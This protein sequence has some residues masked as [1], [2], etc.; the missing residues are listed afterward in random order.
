MYG[1]QE[2]EFFVSAIVWVPYT[3]L[4]FYLFS[5]HY[6][7]SRNLQ[8]NILLLLAS[9]SVFRCAWFFIDDKVWWITSEIVNRIAL[10]LQFSGLS[11]LMLMWTRA[12]AISKMTDIAFQESGGTETNSMENG[13]DAVLVDRLKLRLQR[14]Q[15]ATQAV[16]NKLTSMNSFQHYIIITVLVNVV[17]WGFVLG[18][19]AEQT[20]MW[21]DINIIAISVACVV[22]AVGTLFV[23]LWVSTALHVTLSPVYISN[24]S[25]ATYNKEQVSRCVCMGRYGATCEYVMGCC[26]LCS[27]YAFIFNYNQSD[28]R[29]GLQMQREVLK[30]ILSVSTITSL[31]FL[32]RAFCFIYRPVIEK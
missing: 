21:Y 15:E 1:V 28:T 7:R 5:E 8:S 2:L 3:A 24:S 31:F 6:T 18:S 25:N 29:Q 27:L 11:L 14:Y 19:L 16:M 32:F 22:V 12:I 30:V 10:L 13:R 26:G 17:V 9:G 23:G 20:E 4:L